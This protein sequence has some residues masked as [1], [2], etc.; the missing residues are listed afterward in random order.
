MKKMHLKKMWNRALSLTLAFSM[1]ASLCFVASLLPV[2]G[3][4]EEEEGEPHHHTF[5]C[6]EEYELDCRED[7]AEG[8]HRELCYTYSGE[9]VCGFEEG[10]LHVHNEQECEKVARVLV[11]EEK[12]DEEI[13]DEEILSDGEE[14]EETEEDKK[15]GE[16]SASDENEG[17]DGS[18]AN[19]ANPGAG[20][21]GGSGIFHRGRQRS[22]REVYGCVLQ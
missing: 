5:A 20:S 19:T 1:T 15:N 22:Q 11:C 7:H 4:E 21:S 2:A 12:E 8:E 13:R 3:A 9:L 6:Y 17:G 18:G 10:E 16:G 14:A